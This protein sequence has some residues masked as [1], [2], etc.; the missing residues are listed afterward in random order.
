MVTK[1]SWQETKRLAFESFKS[2]GKLNSP[3]LEQ[4]VKTGCTIGDFDENEKTILINIISSLTRADLNADMWAKVDE[5]IH[6]LELDHDSEASIEY[7]DEE[8]DEF[9]N[10]H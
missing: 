1:S 6:K 9:D 4:I 10:N 7:L 3:E 2:D 8:F 5:L